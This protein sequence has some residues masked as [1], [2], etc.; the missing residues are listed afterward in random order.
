MHPT[1]CPCKAEGLALGL[2]PDLWVDTG[3]GLYKS[4]E[5]FVLLFSTSKLSAAFQPR[6]N[7]TFGCVCF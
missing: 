1:Q 2:M 5:R 4:I 7:F 3:G 6:I